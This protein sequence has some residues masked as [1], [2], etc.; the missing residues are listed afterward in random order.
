MAF[1]LGFKAGYAQKPPAGEDF[2]GC[3]IVAGLHIPDEVGRK[4]IDN[5]Q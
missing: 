2:E 4:L 3:F 5:L 1:F